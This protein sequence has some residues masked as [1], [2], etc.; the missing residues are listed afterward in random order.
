MQCSKNLRVEYMI[1]KRAMLTFV[2]SS[3]KLEG[4][5]DTRKIIQK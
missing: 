5:L 4:T 3:V 1:G 2:A